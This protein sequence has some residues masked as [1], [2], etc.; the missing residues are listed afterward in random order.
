MRR[1]GRPLRFPPRKRPKL[2]GIQPLRD[3][4]RRQPRA[5]GGH[6]GVGAG[7]G[8]GVSAAVRAR[9]LLAEA[10][11]EPRVR[12]HG[13][14]TLADGTQPDGGVVGGVDGEEAIGWG[15]RG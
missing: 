3:L 11:A 9:L 4:R 1:F 13:R 14:P 15:R 8:G 6:E 10:L 7:G 5:F 2:V 12:A